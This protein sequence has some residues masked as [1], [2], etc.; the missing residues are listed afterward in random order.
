MAAETEFL[1]VLEF[2]SLRELDTYK[3]EIKYLIFLREIECAEIFLSSL[4]LFRYHFVT[5]RRPQA[6]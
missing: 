2:I 1:A 3:E 5:A 4:S 6:L